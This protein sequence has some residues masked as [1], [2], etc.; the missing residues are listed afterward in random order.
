MAMKFISEG[1]TMILLSGL[2][3]STAVHMSEPGLAET[4]LTSARDIKLDS[5]TKD[6]IIL[7]LP[8]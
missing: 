8:M 2:G 4:C 5:N 3:V 1:L 7:K 6:R